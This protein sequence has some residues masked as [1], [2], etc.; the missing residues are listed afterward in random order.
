MSFR[1]GSSSRITAGT[2]Y[3]ANLIVFHPDFIVD[4][5][6]FDVAL[7]RVSRQFEGPNIKIIKLADESVSIRERAKAGFAGWG[8]T[9][10]KPLEIKF[11]ENSFDFDLFLIF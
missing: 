10:V 6:E 4:S 3:Q 5:F 9:N 2:I 11:T 8:V 1:A 7:V